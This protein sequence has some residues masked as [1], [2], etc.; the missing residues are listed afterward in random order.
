M[1]QPIRLRD[2]RLP[3]G[4]ARCRC[5]RRPSRA[6][7]GPT[8][9]RPGP[10][11]A[12][13]PDGPRRPASAGFATPP[14]A[15]TAG[16]RTGRSGRRASPARPR[17]RRRGTRRRRAPTCSSAVFRAPDRPC[18]RRVGDDPQL[19]QRRHQLSAGTGREDVVVVDDEPQL[20][21]RGLLPG[22]RAERRAQVV[23][24]IRGVGADDHRGGRARVTTR[25]RRPGRRCRPRTSGPDDGA[26]PSGRRRRSR[27]CR[28]RRGATA[29]GHD[30]AQHAAAV[31]EGPQVALAV[32]ARQLDARHLGDGHAG[33]REAAVDHGLD[34]EPVAPEHACPGAAGASSAG[35]SSI[36]TRSRQKAL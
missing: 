24:A 6:R 32:D 26:R 35:R 4:L 14:T 31:G 34:L 11:S 23:P 12:A 18:L 7:R 20:V 29:L 25:A 2:L 9:R 36:G 19:G 13:S 8:S 22:G 16:R 28:R 10:R 17:R 21:R 15:I 5:S 30:R 27:R 1:L 33:R 3:A